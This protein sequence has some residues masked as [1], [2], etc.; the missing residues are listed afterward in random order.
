[1]NEARRER[2]RELIGM[3]EGI[4][5]QVEMYFQE[6]E[7]AFDDRSPP[8]KETELGII[9]KEAVQSLDRAA[10]DIQSAILQLRFAVGD[11]NWP[12]PASPTVNRR[13]L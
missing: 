1:M 7:A 10:D 5:E 9:S 12:E 2:I 3:P 6:E 8:S 13:G 4:Q 11:D